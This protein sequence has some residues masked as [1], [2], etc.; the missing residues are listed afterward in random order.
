M[1]T[2]ILNNNVKNLVD[3]KVI[4]IT[5]GTGSFGHKLTHTL[6]EFYKPK[7]IIILS[8]DE[9][10]QSEMQKI[11][12]TNLH[13]IRYYIG[14][15]KDK[16][17]LLL[18]FKGVD[19]IFHAAA[20]KQVPAAENNPY[21]AIK[22]NIIGTQNV[23]EAAIERN[24][25]RVIGISTD[26]SV[27]PC[28]LYGGTKLC[29]E[30]LII[31]G[32]NLSG[33]TTL[34]SVLRYGNV[35]GSRGSVVPLFIEQTNK[36]KLTVTDPTMTRFTITLDSAINFVLNCTAEMKGG[37]IF[38]PKLPSYNVLDLAKI[39]GKNI[40]ISIIGARPG[41]KLHEQMIGCTESHLAIDN[42]DKYVIVPSM[43]DLP[44][45]TQYY[46]GNQCKPNW[47]YSSEN[48]ELI[49]TSVLLEMIENF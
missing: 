7:K 32:N 38:I 22:T 25:S 41:E 23:I 15:V 35:F 44:K 29:L 5:G 10:K 40:E 6:L 48:N 9:F 12:N 26:K 27:M 11:F 2:Y 21:E 28:N 43:A 4:L 18:A 19:I 39:I 49:D 30:K 24:V 36:G 42:N 46:N 33:G 31:Y 20:I 3:N 1:M 17:R 37:E 14:D 45:Y 8:R 13:N 34:F 16:D 47:S